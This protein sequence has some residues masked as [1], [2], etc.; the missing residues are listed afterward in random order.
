MLRLTARQILAL[1]TCIV[2]VHANAQTPP[3]R[4]E[5]RQL[6]EEQRAREREDRL[7][8]ETP[9]PKQAEAQPAQPS[10][11]ADPDEVA[12]VEPMFLIQHIALKGNT[13]LKA[14]E[15]RT[16]IAPF[17]AKRLG[18]NRL[19][20]LLR[21]F[22]RAYIEHGYITT[23]VYLGRQNRASGTLEVTVVQGNIEQVRVN[24][25]KPKAD[26]GLRLAF[27]T[28]SGQTLRLQ[29]LEQGIDQL[30]RLPS[31]SA[32]LQ[33]APGQEP[34]G[35]VV[36]ITNQPQR[37]VRGVVGADNYGQDSTGQ[38]RLRLGLEADNLL[39]AYENYGLTYVGSRDTNAVLLST[40]LPVGYNTFSYN[41]YYSEF[42]N[43]VADTALLFGRSQGHTF[44]WNRVLDR[45]QGGKS[46][47]DMSLGLRESRRDVNDIELT[48]Q[49]LTVLRVG[50]N[51]LQRF[52]PGFVLVDGGISSG[53]DALGA[54]TDPTALPRGAAH[55]QYTKLDAS[56]S[57]S[58]Q[59]SAYFTVSSQLAGQFSDQALFSS[60]QIFIG[61]ASTVRGFPEGL[62]SG[63]RG[64]LIR[65]ELQYN[66]RAV[67]FLNTQTRLQPF[68]FVD[69]GSVELIAQGRFQSLASTGIG[70]RGVGRSLSAEV[71]LGKPLLWP[72]AIDVKSLRLHATINY[73]FL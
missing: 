14:S 65:N 9:E 72:D 61:G 46:S 62:L 34:G 45:G 3:V 31:N 73:Q 24:G 67:S 44:A 20:L 38:G 54:T 17:L 69:G 35:S 70:L 55:A 1:V 15:V 27:P 52:G 51:R 2:C 59:L 56:I 50:A 29:D 60:E 33:I 58:V 47:F 43:V 8:Q 10:D 16:L 12:D 23:R 4:D 49:R 13:L 41:Y 48:P 6:L 32:E 19:N 28:W 5:G 64:A 39:G 40:S 71:V 57:G 53:L 30:N 66:A 22:T 25:A 68:A 37:R 18:V 7:L 26:L 36:N 42:V 21:R 63:D 11:L